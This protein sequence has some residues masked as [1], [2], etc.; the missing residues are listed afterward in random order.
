MRE[1]VPSPSF[2]T[3]TPPHLVLAK[4]RSQSFSTYNDL[5]SLQ[6]NK[7]LKKK[8]K[9]ESRSTTDYLQAS[10]T[11][12]TVPHRNYM[13][14][15]VRASVREGDCDIITQRPPARK[16]LRKQNNVNAPRKPK[17]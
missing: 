9:K 17:N 11:K 4:K 3:Y 1:I 16:M 13:L 14:M 5:P 15:C 7:S 2:S 6:K 8:K 12:V 10:N